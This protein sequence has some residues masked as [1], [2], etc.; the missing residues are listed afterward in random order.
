MHL[1]VYVR[2]YAPFATFGGGF[3]GDNRT[4]SE[5]SEASSKTCGIVPIELHADRLAILQPV[6]FSSGS[7]HRLSGEMRGTAVGSVAATVRNRHADRRSASFTLHTEGNLPI[8]SMA[9]SGASWSGERRDSSNRTVE[10]SPDIDTFLDMSIE[11]QKTEI[12]FHGQVR[13]DGFPNLEVFV[14][15]DLGS[16]LGLVDWRTASGWHGPFHRLFGAKS[17]NVLAT[18]DRSAAFHRGQ[19]RS[20]NPPPARLAEKAN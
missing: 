17:K 1:R 10:L 15:D 18:F 20:A 16:A 5:R 19:F 8:T 9:L 13:G 4:Y 3:K 12:R 11:L 7:R 2:R 6:G 14:L